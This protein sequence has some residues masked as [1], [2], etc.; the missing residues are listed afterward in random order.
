MSKDV[1]VA[2]K[3]SDNLTKQVQDMRKGVNSLMRDVSSYRKVQDEAFNKKV[4][5]KF[6]IEQAKRELKELGKAV[7]DNV[8]GS[9]QAFKDKQKSIELLSEEY[10]RLTKVAKEASKAENKLQEDISRTSNRNASR[11]GSQSVLETI[12]KIGIGNMVGESV[13]NLFTQSITSQ[14]GQDVGG[15]VNSIFGGAVSGATYGAAAGLP[16]MAVGAVLGGISGGINAVSDYNEKRDDM[17]REDVKNLYSNAKESTQTTLDSGIQRAGKWEQNKISFGTLLKGDENADRF[18]EDVRQFGAVTPFESEDLLETSKKLLTYGYGQNDILPLMTK[19]G[20]AGSALGMSTEDMN[21]VAT[22]IGRMRSTDKTTLEYLN[23]LMERGIPAM[24]YLAKSLGKSKKAVYEMVSDGLIPG[25]KAAEIIANSMGEQYFG[26][27]EKQSHTYEGLVSTLSDAQAE[28]ERAMGEGYNE[29]RKKGLEQE[30]ETL[31]GPLAEQMKEANRLI[32]TFKAD[33]ENQHQQSLLDAVNDVMNNPENA[34]NQEYMAAQAAG[35]GAT[36][37]RLLEE[38]KVEAEIAYRGTEGYQL[39][40]QADLLLVQNIQNDAT[41]NS[42]Y[43]DYGRK[44][45]NQFSLGYQSGWFQ[46]MSGIVAPSNG[47][48]LVGGSLEQA[49]VKGYA[50]GLDRVPYNNMPALLHEGERVLTKV[51]ADKQDKG[52]SVTPQI[53]ITVHNESGNAYE[54]TREICNQIIKASENF[55]GGA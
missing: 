33:L 2:F 37:G 1:S 54:I 9:E 47:G 36:M 43:Y 45:A 52:A 5:V 7:K 23:P 55:V 44:M 4:E 6:E 42:S 13:Q 18:L 48:G 11:G 51:E 25:A 29:E 27:M 34:R 38:A 28:L 50:T 32:G 41:I 30:I 53:S 19:I 10:R 49:G 39:Q 21:W 17:F 40:Q 26:N 12:G 8:S 22:S 46:R 14:F 35:D 3:A 24:D 15:T 20:D 31:N 16:G